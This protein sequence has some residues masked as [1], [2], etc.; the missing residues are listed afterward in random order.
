MTRLQ[1]PKLVAAAL[2]LIP[3][4]S[5]LAP[6]AMAQANV[7]GQWQT[8]SNQMP[9]NPIHTALMHNGK[10]LVTSGSGNVAN[11]TNF[12]A[13]MFDP[14]TGT[15]TTQS[16]AWDMF[17]NA[18]LVLPDGRVMANGGTLQYDPFHGDPRT[19][20]YD[21]ATGSFT[22]L[23]PMARELRVLSHVSS[24]ICNLRIAH[25]RVE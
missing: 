25:Q 13:G 11:N 19:S 20:A 10:I 6:K 24:P 4:V 2:F 3:V 17:C 18:M 12:Q 14:A 8:L 23:Q 7:T 1:T 5:G 21:P 15:V 16:V 9:I 22:D